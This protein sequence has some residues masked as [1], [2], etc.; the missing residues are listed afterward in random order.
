MVN[1]E[2]LF[3]EGKRK[4]L[5]LSYDDGVEQDQKLIELLNH[6]GVK[7]TFNLSSG[8]YPEE[9]IQWPEGQIH[10]RLTKSGATKVYKDSGHEIAS[11]GLT[12]P[13]LD[14]SPVGVAAHEI[15]EDRKNLE[16]QFGTIVRGFA[17]PYGTYTDQVV[18]TL[19][20]AGMVYA[21]TVHSTHDFAVP[22]DWL[23]MPATCHHDDP[24]LMNLA[25][26]FVEEQPIWNSWL[27]Y[28]WGHTFEFEANNNWNVIEEFLDY[29]GGREDIWYA[30]NIEIHDYVEAY[31]NLEFSYD[32]TM[33]KNPT[34]QKVW[35]R[36]GD[37][38]M[39]IEAGETLYL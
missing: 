11:H 19:R 32:M 13:W 7:A 1:T 28:L 15:V 30:T 26:R 33:V 38:A 36:I 5:T 4:A 3:P 20:N 14:Q 25:K 8:C 35:F 9:G 2:L 27:F 21:R 39:S 12:H 29:V 23:R 17:Y 6:H 16:Q 10:R 22:T 18:E 24:E 31:R 37:Q 34:C